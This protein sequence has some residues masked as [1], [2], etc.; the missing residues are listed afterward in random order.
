MSAGA[1]FGCDS[2][3]IAS[4]GTFSAPLFDMAGTLSLTRSIVWEPGRDIVGGRTPAIITAQD[5][6]L[7]DRSDFPPVDFPAFSNITVG[8][9]RF[10]AQGA[11]DFRLGVNSPA[12]DRAADIGF[13]PTDL[14]GNPRAV[15]QPAVPDQP[16]PVDLGA[17]ERAD[18]GSSS[19]AIFSD[20]FESHTFESNGFESDRLEQANLH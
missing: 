2:C 6:L 9:P 3:T 5:L 1:R 14:D 16:G 19:D 13:P 10:V 8:D 20:G 18:D 17:Y 4:L 7:H 15:D 12:L 11:G